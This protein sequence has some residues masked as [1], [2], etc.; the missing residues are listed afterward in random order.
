M[1]Q[2]ADSVCMFAFSE[3]FFPQVQ[4]F[5]TV[6]NHW[7]SRC[8]VADLAESAQL[9]FFKL[10]AQPSCPLTPGMF[11]RSLLPDRMVVEDMQTEASFR[12]VYVCAGMQQ[13]ITACCIVAQLQGRR[14]T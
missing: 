6:A 13:G 2:V 8:T 9:F 12:P 3:V 5:G 10:K 1:M 7:V 4:R 11:G 14:C